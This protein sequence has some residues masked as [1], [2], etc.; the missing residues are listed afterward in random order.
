[1]EGMV[2][3][4]LSDE[5]QLRLAEASRRSGMTR[6]QWL[7]QAIARELAASEHRPDPH[8]AYLRLMPAADTPPAAAP[9]V[10]ATPLSNDAAHHSRVL[11]SRLRAAD[12]R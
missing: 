12:R 8:A 1:M 10:R 3:L 4:R 11:K 5:Q 2:S 6:S 7:R 9:G